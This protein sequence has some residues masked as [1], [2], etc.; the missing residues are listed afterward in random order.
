MPMGFE[1]ITC[2]SQQSVSP[3]KPRRRSH[4]I[5]LCGGN[6]RERLATIVISARDQHRTAQCDRSVHESRRGRDPLEQ[7]WHAAPPLRPLRA[8]RRWGMINGIALVD[9]P[10]CSP[11]SR[12]CLSPDT[13]EIHDGA[14]TW[15]RTFYRAA[16]SGAGAASGVL[17]ALVL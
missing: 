12:Q 6:A 9:G 14:R 1:P 2:R 4:F 13:Q 8:L 10:C 17:G 3:T 5:E 15:R 7:E 11:S 16:G